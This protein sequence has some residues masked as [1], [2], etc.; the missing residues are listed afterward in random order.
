MLKKDC[1]LSGRLLLVIIFLCLA[2]GCT[3]MPEG[4][5]ANGARWFKLYRC[6]GCHGEN[7]SGGKGPVIAGTSLSFYRFLHKLRS[8]NSAIMPVFDKH[9]LPEK[10]AGEIYLWLQKQNNQG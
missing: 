9:R 2:G 8:P 4:N 3:R 6:V 10:D 5:P 7:G 1:S